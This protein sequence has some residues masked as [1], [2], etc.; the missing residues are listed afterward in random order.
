[1][2]NYII[3]DNFHTTKEPIRNLGTTSLLID[4]KTLYWEPT[5]EDSG[6]NKF[7]LYI[8]DG[9]AADTLIFSVFV[10]TTTTQIKYD[11]AN[12]VATVNEE[13]LY[14]LEHQPGQQYNIINGPINAR[15]SPTGKIHWIPIITQIDNN[16]IEINVINNNK[17][18][19]HTLEIYVNA[20][21]VISYRPAINEAITQQDSLIFQCQSFD[22]NTNPTLSWSLSQNQNTETPIKLTAIG[23]ISVYT[24]TLLDNY[25]YSISLTDGITEDVFNGNVYI[26]DP[27]KIISK[28][29]NYLSLGDTLRYKI[30]TEDKNNE[31]P[32]NKTQPNKLYYKL[33]QSPQGAT[34]HL[35]ENE[36]IWAPAPN[37]I[38]NNNFNLTATDSL[39]ID[40]QNFSIFVNDSPSI[41]SV[42]SLSIA[43]GDTLV[44]YFN[45]DDLNV[46]SELTYSIKTT[47]DELLFSGKAGKLTWVPVE[48]D[49]GLHTLEI[50]VSDGFSSGTDTQKLKIFVY[51]NPTMLNKP[52]TEAFVN[53]EYIYNPLAEDLF[54]NSV[55]GQ[56]II[57]QLESIDS[58]FTGNYIA[59][60][61]TMK[62]MPTIQEIGER[63]LRIIIYDQYN[64]KSIHD[65]PIN[66][67]LSPCE[68]ADSI[69]QTT[70]I[71][72][73]IVEKTDTVYINTD[74]PQTK[75]TQDNLKWKPKGLGF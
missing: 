73:V 62:W 29:Q 56:D 32:F 9:L 59:Q 23:K 60:E 38:G 36:I 17:N 43:V 13:F 67:L 65:Y 64:H 71:D 48:E 19:T 37:Q 45:A 28:P 68:P 69:H 40:T 27:P 61:N 55:V 58:L 25:Q 10:D 49:I 6:I 8:N 20:P 11:Q 26:N 24:D 7:L 46:D 34:L 14:Q 63:K 30:I 39:E 4:S 12:L 52:P 18:E 70:I 72:S 50:N 2:T 44:H 42:D 66:V 33:T 1:M 51:K 31:S 5:P 57:F 3:E 74:K 53:L 21:P 41:I 54:G 16:T 15:I 22:M 75:K 47:I 35:N